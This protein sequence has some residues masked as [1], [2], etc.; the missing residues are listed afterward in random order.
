MQ[1]EESKRSGN[2][3]QLMRLNKNREFLRVASNIKTTEVAVI[4][5]RS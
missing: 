3:L 4:K 1:E 2:Q 5:T